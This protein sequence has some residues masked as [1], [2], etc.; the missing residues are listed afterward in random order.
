MQFVV[1][2]FNNIRRGAYFAVRST[3]REL[4]GQ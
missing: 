2:R 3:R 4:D 1:N